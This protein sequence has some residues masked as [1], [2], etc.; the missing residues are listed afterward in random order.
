MRTKHS[1]P[2]RRTRLIIL[3]VGVSAVLA[4]IFLLAMAPTSGFATGE[5]KGLPSWVVPGAEVVYSGTTSVDG[6]SVTMT[7]AIRVLAM[8]STKAEVLSMDN[9]TVGNGAP[10]S[11]H[12]VDWVTPG[13]NHGSTF[14]LTGKDAIAGQYST[15]Q[16]VQ[17][18]VMSVTADSFETA[19]AQLLTTAYFYRLGLPPVALNLTLGN[20]PTIDLQVTSTNIPGLLP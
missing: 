18:K 19:D 17:G 11:N 14:F 15:T 8:N 1:R 6:S 16:V 2:S 5:T 9:V 7:Y 12:R 4:A 10:I 3:I 13:L 20:F